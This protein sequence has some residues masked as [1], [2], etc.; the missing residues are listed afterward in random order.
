MLGILNEIRNEYPLF[1][2]KKK[3]TVVN[4]GSVQQ[5]QRISGTQLLMDGGIAGPQLKIDGQDPSQVG[6]IFDAGDHLQ[7]SPPPTSIDLVLDNSGSATPTVFLMFDANGFIQANL[8]G[9]YSQASGGSSNVVSINKS[10]GANPLLITGYNYEVSNP[11]QFSNAL[12]I[13]RGDADGS[14]HLIPINAKQAQRNNQFNPNLLTFSTRVY[15]D[16][17]EALVLHVMPNTTVTLTLFIG[18]EYQA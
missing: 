17:N 15:M 2:G 5:R 4:D 6:A 3:G 16:G 8:P 14:V 10:A 9:S 1:K 12:Q 18:G 13:A 7:F 11:A